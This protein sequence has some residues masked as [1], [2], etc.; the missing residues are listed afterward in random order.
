MNPARAELVER[1]A[2][3]R[4]AY[5]RGDHAT[6]QARLV[7]LFEAA[8]SIADRL[9]PSTSG[10]GSIAFVSGLRDEAARAAQDLAA[11][12]PA[13]DELSESL[14]SAYGTALVLADFADQLAAAERRN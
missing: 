9:L 14:R 5:A 12:L 10:A 1:Y 13:P 6:A 4:T 8:A 11:S 7:V 3:A 2:E